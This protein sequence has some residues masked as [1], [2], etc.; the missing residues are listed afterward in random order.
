MVAVAFV[1]GAWA[2]AANIVTGDAAARLRREADRR[3][4]EVDAVMDE[5]LR[6]RDAVYRVF[7]RLAECGQPGD[8]DQDDVCSNPHGLSPV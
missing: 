1:A 2:L 7:S 3:P 5:A 6:L 4:A 8:D